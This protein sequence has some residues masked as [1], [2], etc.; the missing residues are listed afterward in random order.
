M[1]VSQKEEQKYSDV[2][3]IKVK[4][5]KYKIYVDKSNEKLE[6]GDYVNLKVELLPRESS[7]GNDKET[8]KV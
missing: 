2:Y 6:Y 4:R 1:I 8:S 3:I 7:P 5:K